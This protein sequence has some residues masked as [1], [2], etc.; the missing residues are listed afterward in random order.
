VHGLC[1]AVCVYR[2]VYVC[3]Y[4]VGMCVCVVVAHFQKSPLIS[5]NFLGFV[6]FS[7]SVL[8]GLVRIIVKQQRARFTSNEHAVFFLEF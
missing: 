1:V 2:C 5:V 4:C 8:L 6:C 7:D 3:G